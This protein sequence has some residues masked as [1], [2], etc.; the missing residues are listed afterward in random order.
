MGLPNEHADGAG[1]V[2]ALLSVNVGMPKEVPWH[3]K[4]VFTGVFKDP[5]S[6]PRRVGKLN[7][8]GERRCRVPD[9]PVRAHRVRQAGRRTHAASDS[10][11]STACPFAVSTT[12]TLPRVAFE[13]GQIWSAALTSSTA[14]T[15]SSTDGSETASVTASL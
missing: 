15:S 13:Y 11:G 10:A 14:S 6:G 4:K 1:P 8:E 5:V 7:V 9:L 2:G 12:S 3:G